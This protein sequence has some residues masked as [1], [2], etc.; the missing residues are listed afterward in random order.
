M[1]SGQVF[2]IKNNQLLQEFQAPKILLD[3]AKMIVI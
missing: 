3:F 1:G 2:K